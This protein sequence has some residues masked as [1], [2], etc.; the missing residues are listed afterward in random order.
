MTYHTSRMICVTT[1][2]HTYGHSYYP[3]HT[4]IPKTSLLEVDG[5]IKK[6]N[7]I[8]GEA[9]QSYEFS[10]QKTNTICLVSRR[11]QNHGQITPSSP[12][13]NLTWT[14]YK[15]RSPSRTFQHTLGNIS[16]IIFIVNTHWRHHVCSLGYQQYV[17]PDIREQHQAPS[18]KLGFRVFNLN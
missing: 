11:H 16:N 10:P 1:C 13:N 4:H 9:C 7:G 15:N 5:S 3:T 8:N 12:S 14:I 18:S 17:P 6:T 2:M